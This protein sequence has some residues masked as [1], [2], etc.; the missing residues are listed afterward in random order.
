MLSDFR[1]V[2]GSI[3]ST[4]CQQ[5]R[6]SLPELIIFIY[7]NSLVIQPTLLNKYIHKNNMVSPAEYCEKSSYFEYLYVM[8]WKI[9]IGCHLNYYVYCLAEFVRFTEDNCLTDF[10]ETFLIVPQSRE[11]VVNNIKLPCSDKMADVLNRWLCSLF[12]IN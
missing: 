7:Y 4:P 5:M 11:K 3:F 10:V 1:T 9:W 8:H 12:T 6:F 2:L